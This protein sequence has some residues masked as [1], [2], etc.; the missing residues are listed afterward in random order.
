MNKLIATLRQVPPQAALQLG[1]SHALLLASAVW[2]AIPYVVLQT[3][4]AAELLLINIVTIPLYP[5]RGVLRHLGDV[6]KMMF[7]LAFVL[8]FIV[9]SYGVVARQAGVQGEPLQIALGAFAGL[10]FNDA[11]WGI[12]YVLVR[13][14][15]SMWQARRTPDPRTAW[16]SDNL[17][18]GG[19]T[20][21]AM[22]FIVFVAFFVAQPLM[23]GLAMI[24]VDANVDVV[25]STLMVIVRYGTA[26][27]ASTF[28][29]TGVEEIARQPYAD[30]V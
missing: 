29:K 1:I 23:A 25:L 2:G 17:L 27:I 16:A 8:F 19:S 20:F 15:I 21:V 4:L 6:V 3:M 11:M 5:E 26:L 7:A 9:I 30:S 18:F 12:S 24:G 10:G 22:F 13:L 14:S 28:S